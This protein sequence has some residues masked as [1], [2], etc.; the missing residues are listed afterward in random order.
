[1]PEN[2]L[3]GTEIGILH[4]LRKENPQKVF[5]AITQ[6]ADCS[7]M[8]LISLEKVLWS[9]EDMVY[10]VKVSDDIA[11]KARVAIQKMLDLS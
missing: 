8:K 7:N 10:Q 3:S 5:Y 2:L 6:L 1:M 9:L 4:R 11:A